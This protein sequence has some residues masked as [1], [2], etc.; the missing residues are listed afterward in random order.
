MIW[1]VLQNLLIDDYMG[2]YWY[3]SIYL[4]ILYIMYIYILCIYIYYT[5]V[6][7]VDI[8]MAT[9]KMLRPGMFRHLGWAR[10]EV[11]GAQKGYPWQSGSRYGD[12][13]ITL[14]SR[15]IYLCGYNSIPCIYDNLLEIPELEL[16]NAKISDGKISQPRLMTPV[17]SGKQTFCFWIWP[18][19][20]WFTYWWWFSIAMSAIT[21]LGKWIH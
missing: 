16:S 4:Y 21:R 3:Y 2:W 14:G 13:T 12:T 1:T 9:P 20:R 6:W 5:C 8:Y 17:P 7:C 18:I 15:K 10:P 19:Y 11:S